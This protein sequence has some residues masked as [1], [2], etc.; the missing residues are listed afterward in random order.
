MIPDI[1]GEAHQFIHAIRYG[2]PFTILSFNFC[3]LA[4]NW[5]ETADGYPP[6]LETTLK[7][8]L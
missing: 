4:K 1:A 6:Q 3:A 7:P 2:G 5:K 8:F